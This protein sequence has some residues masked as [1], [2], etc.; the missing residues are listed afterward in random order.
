MILEYKKWSLILLSGIPWCGKSTFAKKHFPKDYIISTDEIR[1]RYFWDEHKFNEDWTISIGNYETNG[2]LIFSIVMKI[3]NDRCTEWLSTVIDATNLRDSDR[4]RFIRLG[5]W[6]RNYTIIFDS[7]NAL[8]QNKIRKEKNIRWYVPE[9]VVEKMSL[10]FNKGTRIKGNNIIKAEKITEVRERLDNLNLSEENNI[11]VYGDV[12]G[13]KD[14]YK[15]YKLLQEKYT[16]NQ[17]KPLNLFVWDIVDRWN[18]SVDNLCF[19]MSEVKKWNAKMVMGNHELKLLR[20][21]NKF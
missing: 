6:E 19:V 9:R 21:I 17:N 10:S 16:K 2:A 14:F 3:A 5:N 1:E 13:M 20:N 4:K 8:E 15:N 7:E 11:L 12:H 18:Y